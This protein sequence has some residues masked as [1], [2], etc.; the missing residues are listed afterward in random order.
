MGTSGIYLLGQEPVLPQVDVLLA[1]IHRNVLLEQ[2]PWYAQ[3]VA[4]NGVL[5]VSGIHPEDKE[6]LTAAAAASGLKF[7]YFKGLNDWIMIRFGRY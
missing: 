6:D 4:P 1:N 2:M 5:M 3:H 7:D